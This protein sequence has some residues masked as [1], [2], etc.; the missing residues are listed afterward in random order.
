MRGAVIL[1]LALGGCATPPPA[2]WQPPLG[3]NTVFAQA[4]ESAPDRQ[5]IVADLRL[6]PNAVGV[7]HFHP[8]EEFLYVIE[9]SALLEIAG[10]PPRTLLDVGVWLLP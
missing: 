2:A 7:T 5:L 3:S 1:A 10:E 8:W 9:G 4:P 6:G